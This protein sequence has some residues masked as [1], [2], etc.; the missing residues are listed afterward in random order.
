MTEI[1]LTYL[2]ENGSHYPPQGV[3]PRS[4][5]S[6]RFTVQY[7]VTLRKP[8]GWQS[9]RVARAAVNENDSQNICLRIL[10][11]L[12]NNDKQC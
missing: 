1:C 2:I 3:S 4:L 11:H 9:E 5:R 6:L 7:S 10:E 12:I 8:V